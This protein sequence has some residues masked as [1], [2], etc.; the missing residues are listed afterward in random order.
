VHLKKTFI[1]KK[2]L[3]CENKSGCQRSA[4][5]L[6]ALICASQFTLFLHSP[7]QSSSCSDF[8]KTF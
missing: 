7:S 4:L 3:S 2:L 8:V 5:K 1:S 6:C